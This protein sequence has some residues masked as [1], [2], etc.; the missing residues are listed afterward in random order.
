MWV[1]YLHLP[2]HVWSEIHI[3]VKF[4]AVVLEELFVHI[5]SVVVEGIEARLSGGQ[6]HEVHTMASLR[7]WVMPYSRT[8]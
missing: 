3:L 1:K 5:V 7:V 8:P 2:A 4:L 6:Y